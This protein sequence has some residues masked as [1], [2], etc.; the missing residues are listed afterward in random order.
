MTKTFALIPLLAASLAASA[1]AQELSVR[2]GYGDLDLAS[3]AGVARFDRRIDAAIEQVCG[4][5][6]GQRPLSKVL[7]ILKCSRDTRSDVA[8]PREVAIAR[9]RGKLP[10]VEL[11]DARSAGAYALLVR[12]R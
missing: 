11:A 1:Q 6:L 3:D 5:G 12:R 8:A 2:V 7:A 4:D 9:A 10:S